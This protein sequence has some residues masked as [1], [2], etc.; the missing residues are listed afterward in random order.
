MASIV[1]NAEAD[2]AQALIGYLKKPGY[3]FLLRSTQLSMY[4]MNAAYQ[5]LG[6]KTLAPVDRLEKGA[7]PN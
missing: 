3:A 4:W 1:R 7:S 5:A 6:A 2:G